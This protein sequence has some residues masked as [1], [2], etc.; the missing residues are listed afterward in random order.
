ML[1][2]GAYSIYTPA[3]HCTTQRCIFYIHPCTLYHTGAHIL[4]T[5]LHCCTTRNLLEE[6]GEGKKECLVGFNSREAGTGGGFCFTSVGSG[7]GRQ[8]LAH[9]VH[10]STKGSRQSPLDPFA[11]NS[12]PQFVLVQND[13][14]LP[15]KV[16]KKLHFVESEALTEVNLHQK[17]LW[18]NHWQGNVHWS[19][20]HTAHKAFQGKY[21]PQILGRF[22][23][24]KQLTT[25]E[26]S[27]KH[28]S[29][30]KEIWTQRL[31]QRIC[32]MLHYMV[33]HE[34]G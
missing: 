21:L 6:G 29:Q 31:Q 12:I 11:Y 4:Y 8:M 25:T 24:V 34:N 2:R 18:K 30:P 14:K 3:L 32:W 26:L 23:K 15:P 19:H 20:L 9:T 28:V 27:R 7:K 16:P 10:S 17:L 22:Q 13:K 33:F 1:P 5:P